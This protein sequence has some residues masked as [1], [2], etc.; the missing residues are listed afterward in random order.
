M[1]MNQK[2]QYT[3]APIAAVVLTRTNAPKLSETSGCM[4]PK[5]LSGRF[6]TKTS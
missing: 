2:L 5:T 4:Y 3:N 1:A 6:P